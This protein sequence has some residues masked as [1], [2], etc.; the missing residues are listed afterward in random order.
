MEKEILKD[1][2]VMKCIKNICDYYKKDYRIIIN[3]LDKYKIN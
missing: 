3:F 2:K 1:N